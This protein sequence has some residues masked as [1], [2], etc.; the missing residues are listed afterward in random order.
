MARLLRLRNGAPAT[1]ECV[2]NG[3]RSSVRFY[4]LF[5]DHHPPPTTTP[6]GKTFPSKRSI[7]LFTARELSCGRVLCN[8]G[9]D[10]TN[11]HE[12]LRETP[13]FASESVWTS[14]G[15]DHASDATPLDSAAAELAAQA[16]NFAELGLGGYSPPGLVQSAL[17]LIHTT[18]HLPWWA[19]IAAATVALRIALF[20]LAVRMQV[21][22]AKIANIN[23]IAQQLH[24]R[25]VAYKNIGNKVA[26]AQEAAKLLSIYREQGVHPITT[27]FMMPLVQVPIFISFFLA[28]K[29]MAK[30]PLESMKTG[31]VYWFTDLTVPDPTYML[32][33][34]ACLTFI[35][36]IEVMISVR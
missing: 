33:L 20:P 3:A 2:T 30:L 12:L 1:F 32:P 11:D 23:P 17:E 35:S 27:L 8:V 4:R 28:I 15:S 29:G 5:V 34:L 36:N 24:K 31:G 25:M 6:R 10:R 18:T 19:S 7:H 21:N 14:G 13:T 26:E 9:E 22:A 16:E